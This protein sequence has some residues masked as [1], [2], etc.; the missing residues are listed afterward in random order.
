MSRSASCSDAARNSAK[1]I[2]VDKSVTATLSGNALA[3]CVKYSSTFIC[4]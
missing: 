1:V 3:V 4:I 2:D